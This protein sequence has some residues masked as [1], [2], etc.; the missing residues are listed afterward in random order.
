MLL[1]FIPQTPGPNPQTSA[2]VQAAQ[3]LGPL[4]EFLRRH[5]GLGVQLILHPA[6]ELSDLP[7][8][9]YYRYALPQFAGTG[10]ICTTS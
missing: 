6:P 3:K 5:T 1:G 4:L 7:L 10:S 2:A 8:R 9:S